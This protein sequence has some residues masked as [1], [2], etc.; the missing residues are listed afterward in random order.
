[1]Y[2]TETQDCSYAR[3]LI[4]AHLNPV[5]I[6]NTEGE[7]TDMNHIFVVI[8]GKSREAVLGTDCSDYFSDSKKVKS[9]CKKIFKDGFINDYELTITDHKQKDVLFNGFVYKNGTGKVLG[10]FIIARDIAKQK[11]IEDELR[12]ASKIAEEATEIA[13]QLTKIAEE[14]VKSKQQFLSNM[15]HEIRTPM[16]AI[17]GFTKVVLKTELTAKQKEYLTAIKMSGDALILLINDIL[18]LAKVDAGKMIFE[19]SPFKLSLSISAMLHL[20]ETKIQEK[21]LQLITEY[22]TAIPEVLLGDPARLHQIILNLVSNAVKFTN[23][24]KITV[25]VRLVSEDDKHVTVEFAVID[26]G[27]GIEEKKIDK[28]FENFQQAYNLTSRL[29]GGTGLGLAIVK[30]LVEAQ[31][32][33][34]SVESKI[35]EG[36][37]FSFV[38]KFRKT[39][40]EAVLDAEIIELDSDI[41]NVNILVV[42]DMELNQLLM[43]TLLDDFGFEC[44]ITANGKLAI[45]K[46]A[47]KSYDIILMDLQM[48]EMNGFEATKYI[49]NIMKSSIP[50]I[51]LT[52]DVTTVDVTK[53]KAVGMNDYIAKPV[54]E[55]LLY[56]KIVGLLKKPVMI[57]EQKITGNA[58][59]GKVK[60]VDMEYLIKLTKSNPVLIKEMI[61]AYLKQT[62]PLINTMKQSLK[63]KDWI[64]LQAAV[65][66]MIPSFTI[67]GINP[68]IGQIAKKI[69][70][71]AYTI[72][73][74]EEISN[75]VSE[76]ETVCNH[77]CKELELE[78]N[79]IKH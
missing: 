42:E 77:A 7:I 73:I 8:T 9:A 45:E 55:R 54:D 44:D 3:S 74:S 19:K 78:L 70:D 62:P 32:G 6:I 46:L 12:E 49:R 48:P 63:D 35:D 75:L 66:K 65:H 1:M 43:K 72:E 41:K 24:G 69:Q 60:Y 40:K 64:S 2:T 47:T 57:I 28:I 51:A 31:G 27:I 71:Y 59:T 76:L 23:K 20:F 29:Y 53:C 52:A 25:S 79:N 67:M 13:E 4:E 30:Q 56:S 61:N 50:I 21:N 10:A 37:T 34:I 22:D 33:S 17:I 11:K 16:N 58:E 38:L 36:A 14:A 68:S 26:T 18:D 5:I 39:N 15:S